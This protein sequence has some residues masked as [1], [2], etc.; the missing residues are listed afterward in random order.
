MSCR[1]TCTVAFVYMYIDG[2][3]VL[4]YGTHYFAP[5]IT[6]LLRRRIGFFTFA[7]FSYLDEDTVQD[8][9]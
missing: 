5:Q 1:D 6:V 8:K 4:V 2:A 7:G 3:R 9:L